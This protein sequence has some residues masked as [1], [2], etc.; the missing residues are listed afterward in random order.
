MTRRPV[1]VALLGSIAVWTLSLPAAAGG[2]KACHAT[3]TSSASTTKIVLNDNCITPTLARVPVGAP[4][5]WINKDP[6]VHTV[7][8]AN[9]A[10]GSFKDL[11][12]DA[13]MTMRFTKA[14]VYP[15]YCIY[16]PGM[17]AAVLVGDANGPGIASAASVV[18]PIDAPAKPAAVAAKAKTLGAAWPAAALVTA[19]ATGIGGFGLGRRAKRARP[20]L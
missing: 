18:D 14:G 7:T 17:A 9:V 5:T 20:E 2:G 12:P 3:G 1:L 16:H 19:A 15:Y 4:V 8:G 11:V 13:T 10:W 6:T